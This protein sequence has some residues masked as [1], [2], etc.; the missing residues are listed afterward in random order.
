MMDR[1]TFIGTLAGSLLATPLAAEGQQPGRMPRIGVLLPAEPASP[2]EPNASAFRQGLRDLGYV[3]GQTIGVEYR[4]A[5][6]RNERYAELAHELLQLKVDVLVAGGNSSFAARDATQTIPIVSIAAGDLIGAGLVTSLARPGGNLTGLS[7]AFD[8]GIIKKWVQLLKEAAPKVS[9]LGLLR[10][11]RAPMLQPKVPTDTETAAAALGLK[12]R[13]VDVRELQELD[14]VFAG[15]SKE[16]GY[17][18]IVSGTRL[19]FPHRSRIHELAITYRLP[20]MY[21]WRVFV[22]A[23]GLMSYG[24]S[25]SD[26]WRR[27]ATYVDKILKGAKPGD[28]P[29][30]EPTKFELIINRKAA[31]A[32]GL[33]IPQSLLLRA[34]QVI[35]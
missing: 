4:Y 3:E 29:V 34:D 28:L 35:E 16:G 14:G 13:V 22:D 19:F 26:L 12:F 7:I 15:L 32:I 30:E 1:R 25:L 17:G 2:T 21:S 33:T 5:H 11:A 18:L 24:A 20:V 10:D 9:R 8:E 27:G 31:K 6:G 23:G